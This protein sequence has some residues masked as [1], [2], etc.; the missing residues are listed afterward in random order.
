MPESNTATPAKK[1]D[2]VITKL[3]DAP[4]ERVWQAWTDPELV[5][6]WWGPNCFTAP[7]AKM[8]FR[9]GGTSLVCMRAPDG[10]DMYSTWTYQRIVPNQRIEYIHNLADPDGNKLDPVSLGFPDLPQDVRNVI[11]FKT[12]NH[13]T[14]M[15]VT[16][17]GF[18]TGQMYNM[19]RMGLEQCLDKM[20]A[21]FATA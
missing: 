19:A 14:E 3:F 11:T 2:V 1:Y 20:A 7:M 4:I 15:T 17:Y 8:D 12:V 5:M 10:P 21:I 13:Q 18:P 6:R 16:E 9:E